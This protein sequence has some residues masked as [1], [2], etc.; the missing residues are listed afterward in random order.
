MIGIL[1]SLPVNHSD[2]DKFF[3]D[4]GKMVESIKSS[5]DIKEYQNIENDL[6]EI[7]NK[8]NKKKASIQ[9]SEKFDDIKN[10]MTEMKGK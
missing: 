10:K 5:A 9:V 1:C 6:I 4:A 8:G 2:L 7:F 3:A